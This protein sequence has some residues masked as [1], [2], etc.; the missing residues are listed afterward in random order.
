MSSTYKLREAIPPEHWRAMGFEIARYVF[1][2]A[3][4]LV[5]VAATQPD[6]D[7]DRRNPESYIDLVV[8]RRA[9]ERGWPRS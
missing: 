5:R 6:F 2:D 8:S 4:D 9:I 7:K 1:G 3:E